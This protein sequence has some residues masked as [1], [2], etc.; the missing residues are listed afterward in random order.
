MGYQILPSS[1]I[2]ANGVF[3]IPKK[4]IKKIKFLDSL[5]IAVLTIA[6]SSEDEITA[7]AIAKA[8]RENELDVAEALEFWVLQGVLTDS[9]YVKP[10]VTTDKDSEQKTAL[11]KLP[12]PNLTARDIVAMSRENLEISQLLQGA[13]EI[14][15]TTIS[16]AMQS[17]LVNMVTYYG[18]PVAVVLTLLQYYKSEREK[19]KNITVH[20]LMNM[21]NEW[22]NEEIDNLEKASAKLQELEDIEEL[23]QFVI[24]KCEFEYKKPTSSQIK[25]LLRWRADFSQD[26]ILFA[27]NTMK[28]YNEKDKH[29]I[30]HID[31]ILRDWKRKGCSTPNEVK[32]YKK[33]ENK[34]NKSKDKLQGK[35]SF[36]IESIANDTILNDNFDV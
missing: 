17:N 9:S 10:E 36:D 14:L 30:K 27:I 1:E 19:G 15:G 4:A 18:L 31:V 25:M 11:E 29:S 22:A 23:W 13:Q 7:S 2:W 12:M 34:T 5:K 21:A 16:A 20:K 3:C 28:K 33:E 35:P 24:D 6:L 26:M 8:L 32:N